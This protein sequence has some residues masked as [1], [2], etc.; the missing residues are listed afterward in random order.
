MKV[1]KIMLIPVFMGLLAINASGYYFGGA[2][3]YAAGVPSQ[4]EKRLFETER[5]YTGNYAGLNEER[6]E[7]V[8]R[9]DVPGL[10]GRQMVLVPIQIQED[11]T[12]TV[13]YK[14]G[15][16]KVE[17]MG[18]AAWDKLMELKDSPEFRDVTKHVAVMGDPENPSRVISIDLEPES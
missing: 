12:L 2:E 13:C 3:D 7:I 14:G 15:E 9:T 10:L 11:T 16:C 18:R 5:F 8:L 4:Q 1:L 17:A 6:N